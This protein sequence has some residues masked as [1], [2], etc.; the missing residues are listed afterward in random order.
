MV[1]LCANTAISAVIPKG[2]EYP[3]VGAISGH[4]KAPAISFHGDQGFVAWQNETANSGGQRI[5]VQPINREGVGVGVPTIISQNAVDENELSPSVACL[6]NGGVAVWHGGAR[7]ES[8]IF[9]RMIGVNGEAVGPI[10]RVN[11]FTKGVQKN[12]KVVRSGSAGFLVAWSSEQQDGDR[13]GVFGRMFDAQ[14]IPKGPE[15]QINQTT[16]YGQNAVSIAWISETTGIAVWVC[17]QVDGKNT[18]GGVNYRT[19]LMGRLMGENGP[20]KDEFIVGEE[21]QLA[22]N[23]H[24]A[25]L[26][27]GGF[28]VIWEQFDELRVANSNDIFVQLFTNEIVPESPAIRLNT[29][30]PGAQSKPQLCGVNGEVFGVWS[31]WGLNGNEMEIRGRLVAKGAEFEVNS[32]SNLDQSEPVIGLLRSNRAV[33][34]WVNTMRADNSII[35][36]QIFDIGDVKDEESERD[37][38]AG[39][40]EIIGEELVQ[41]GTAAEVVKDRRQVQVGNTDRKST[42]KPLQ[43][44]FPIKTMEPKGPTV[45]PAQVISAESNKPST[46]NE[47]VINAQNQMDSN[48]AAKLTSPKALPS[49]SA[50]SLV[51]LQGLGR[52]QAGYGSQLRNISGQNRTAGG[53]SPSRTALVTERFASLRLGSGRS[54]GTGIN[55]INPSTPRTYGT[56]LLSAGAAEKASGGGIAPTVT[57]AAQRAAQI[58]NSAKQ[59]TVQAEIGSQQVVPAGVVRTGRG[60]QLK[61]ITQGGGRYQIQGSNDRLSWEQI[62]SPRDGQSQFDAVDI[63]SM[64]WRYYRVIRVN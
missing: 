10:A 40:V 22:Q 25:R 27:N 59:N 23:P 52:E 26:G 4:Q 3:L 13:M 8:D 15:F 12:A 18:S 39:P 53:F 41:R 57:T 56:S 24:V 17:E 61:W 9:M 64:G 20:T 32:Q 31:S 51:A 55:V 42:V 7:S 34:G 43:A 47:A 21:G 62:G 5:L 11:E 19:T 16:K 46:R 60:S 1:W 33:V 50:A 2:G 48:G 6:E 30:L 28:G 49:S 58:Q 38:A 44:A 29:Y 45:T 35:S 63:T 36:A 37:I 14:G 54:R